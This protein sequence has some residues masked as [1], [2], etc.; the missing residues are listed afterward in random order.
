MV[1]VELRGVEP[2]REQYVAHMVYAWYQQY[3]LGWLSREGLLA[4]LRRLSARD[5]VAL[6]RGLAS[7]LD[8]AMVRKRL[9]VNRAQPAA[10]FMPGMRPLPGVTDISELAA[11]VS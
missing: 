8:L 9:S 11:R 6:A 10:E 5:Y 7:R 1:P 2:S 3:R 4:L